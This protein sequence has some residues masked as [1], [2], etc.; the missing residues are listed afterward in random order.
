[1]A[2]PK[3]SGQSDY[4]WPPILNAPFVQFFLGPALRPPL[5]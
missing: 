5:I 4:A 2:C 3:T 1:M